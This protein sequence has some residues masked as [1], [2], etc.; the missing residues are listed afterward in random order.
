MCFLSFK[1]NI[2]NYFCLFY[3]KFFYIWPLNVVAFNVF[4]ENLFLEVPNL[5]ETENLNLTQKLLEKHE[6]K[7]LIPNFCSC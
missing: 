6:L 7:V 2:C 3:F 4:Q 1:K 5:K